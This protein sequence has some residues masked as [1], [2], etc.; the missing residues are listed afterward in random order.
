MVAAMEAALTERGNPAASGPID[1][2]I[3]AL[4]AGDAEGALCSAGA[5]LGASPDDAVAALVVARGARVL[6][7]R[8]LATAAARHALDAALAA[9]QFPAAVAAAREL[10]DL[11]SEGAD[12]YDRI[13]GRFA[14]GSE[15]PG[16]RR[17][18]P[19]A[20]ATASST[21]A[22]ARGEGLERCRR[23]VA[24]AVV[25]LGEKP[26]AWRGA[27]GSAPP[28]TS[29]DRPGLRAA[30][31][32]LEVELRGPGAVLV[33]QGTLG[34]E[35]FLVIRGELE[36]R[37]TRADGATR[38][39]DRLG[40]GALVGEV[41]LLSRAPRAG[42]VVVVRPSL[43]LVAP[44]AA[45]DAV[46]ARRPEVGEELAAH[47]RGRMVTSLVRNSSIFA[48]IDASER[49]GVMV[50]FVT[51]TYEAGELLIQ[52]AAETDGLHLVASGE[53]EVRQ[54]RGDATVH[55]ADLGIGEVVGEM[56]LVL[57]RPAAADVIAKVPTVTLHLPRD[58][59]LD[60]I[61]EHPAVL[62]ELYDLAVRRDQQATSVFALD[63]SA[64][65][66]CITL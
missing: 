37:R 23:A 55:V 1:D 49:L 57:R 42:S 56:G 33:E 64:A 63:S 44:E 29:L 59:F 24:D 6:E 43:L 36:V 19:P 15:L 62:G 58:G 47:C 52:Q 65:D 17:P 28:F 66:S 14:R 26:P 40:G 7:E 34:H 50:R 45:L 60:L 2:A 30:V 35:A 13:A 4:L 8:E 18:V 61:K 48:A 51:R 32:A 12:A 54:H 20:L 41:A 53:V 10:C 21:P 39:I 31:E 25:A 38:T 27:G 5:R 22:F 11:G 9:G 3:V 46:V 16:P